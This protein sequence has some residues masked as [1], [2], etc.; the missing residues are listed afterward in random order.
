MSGE[1]PVRP[2]GP[3]IEF[4]KYQ[5]LGN[6]FIIIFIEDVTPELA[7]FACDRHFGIGA[8]GIIR[9]VPSSSPEIDFHFRLFNA[10]GG[11][12]EVSGNGL[13]CVGRFLHE[14]GLWSQPRIRVECGG[15]IKVVEIAVAEGEVASVRVDMGVP[16]LQ[17]TVELFD[18]TWH[19]VATGNPH[20]VTIVEDLAVVPILELGPQV[21]THDHFPNRTNV[22][23]VQV[24][25][26]D[27]LAVRFWERGVGVTL[28]SG[29]GSTAA[30]AAAGLDRAT[31][32]TLGGDLVV[33]R[34]EDGH[35]YQ[36]GPAAH[37]YDGALP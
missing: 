24:E 8:D 1:V 25:G 29:S 35:L 20:A 23:F 16:Q 5:G 31:V 15:D 22:E 3:P 26:D 10:D 36:T 12:A 9:L 21:E 2:K 6:D 30:V 11:V 14:A 33:E 18:R 32:R 13:R 19:K 27:A 28:A 37:V 4:S 7:R 17:G 34:G